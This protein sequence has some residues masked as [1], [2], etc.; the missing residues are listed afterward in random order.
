MA[1][2]IF[3]RVDPSQLK[4]H[5]LNA[6]IY[7]DVA[8]DDLV[9]SMKVKGQQQAIVTAADGKTIVSGHRRRQ[10]AQ[11]LKWKE[12]DV[13]V[14]LTLTDKL[15]IAAAVIHAN[16]QREKTVEQKAREYTQLKEIEEERAKKRQGHGQTARG[17][18]A[19][20]NISLSVLTPKNKGQSRDKAAEAVGFGSGKTAEAAAA[21]VDEIDKAESRGHNKKA[22][23]LRETLETKGPHAAHKKVSKPKKKKP[24]DTPADLA[25]KNR[26]LAQSL[27]DKAARAVDDLHQVKPNRTKRDKAVKLLQEAGGLLW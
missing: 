26:K 23:S 14:D 22:S 2:K 10:G 8:D 4:N 27:I 11:I 19:S 7:G 12:V 25:K 20:G 15:D 5:P 13:I 6:K 24:E 3:K 18:N 9:E 16:K 17:R 21:V 1:K